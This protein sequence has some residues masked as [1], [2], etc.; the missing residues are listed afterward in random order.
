[1]SDTP[2][3]VKSKVLALD[4][5]RMCDDIKKNRQENVLTNNVIYSAVK[6]GTN[7]RE[8]FYAHNK[9]DFIA[10]LQAA[11]KDCSET[12]YLLELLID[13]GYH[14]DTSVFDN[15]NE[16][17]KLLI[18]TIIQQKAAMIKAESEVNR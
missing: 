5:I 18:A 6:I 3:I 10:N 17:K 11:L 4:I 12:E 9:A 7:I 14:N 8:A 13:S 16:I 1:M 15:C 2:M